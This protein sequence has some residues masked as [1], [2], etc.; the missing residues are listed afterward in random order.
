MMLEQHL[1]SYVAQDCF[2]SVFLVLLCQRI[3]LSY[4][5]LQILKLN[6]YFATMKLHRKDFF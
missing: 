2:E 1:Q 4:S 5:A 3:T 6:L